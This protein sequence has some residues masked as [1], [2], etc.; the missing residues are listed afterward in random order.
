MVATYLAPNLLALPE[1][2]VHGTFGLYLEEGFVMYKLYKHERTKLYIYCM[3]RAF[4][5]IEDKS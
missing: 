2:E 1:P 5:E 3:I 4:V